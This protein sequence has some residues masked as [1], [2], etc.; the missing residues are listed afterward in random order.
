MPRGARTKCSSNVY[1]VMLRGANR[2]QI[3][4]DDED[5]T[6]FLE[7]LDECKQLG[8]FAIYAYCLMGNHA[9]LLIKE[10][11]EPLEQ[12]MKRIAIRYV[13]WF[14][15]KYER[16]GH[17]FQDRFKSE[18]VETQ[19]YFL[20]VI[21]YIHQN[22]V[23]AGICQAVG[24]YAYSSY[25]EYVDT[26]RMIDKEFVYC[27]ISPEDFVIVHGQQVDTQCLELDEQE[28][29]PRVTD[30]QARRIIEKHTKCKNASD[31]QRLDITTRNKYLKL[32]KEHGL[33][34]RQISRLT[35][36]SFGIVSRA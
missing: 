2:Q 3:F 14:N 6:R 20:T 28:I 21:R 36:I 8:G 34:I 13:Y 4:E 10:Q 24:D 35:G 12:I 16:N 15:V 31:F 27:H 26:T 5:Y 30:E 17:L 18:P 32:L 7:I 9:H 25:R 1:H 33:S 29:S 23:K 11:N 22:P 19:H